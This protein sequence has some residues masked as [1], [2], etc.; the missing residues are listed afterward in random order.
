MGEAIP[1][2]RRLSEDLTAFRADFMRMLD[3][4]AIRNIDPNRWGGG[5]FVGFPEWGW[6][7]SDPS[8]ERT[9]ME[10][11]AR[12]KELAHRWRL[13]FPTPTPRVAETLDHA[14]D[15]IHI[16]IQ[17]EAGDQSV[18]G[19]IEAAKATG[20]ECFGQLQELLTMLPAD[21]VPVRLVVDTNALI[22]DPDLTIY[23][24]TMG[25]HYTV[26]LLPVVLGELDDLHRAGRTVELRSAAAAAGRRI[27]GYR[28]NGDIR[29]GVRVQAKIYMQFEH[30]EPDMTTTLHW[31]DRQVPDDRLVAAALDLQVR[32]PGSAA[33]DQPGRPNT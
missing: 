19:G 2:R 23:K 12:W 26:H 24:P 17:R 7:P 20:D 18:P 16:W 21:P 15:Q 1:F 8:H 31:L 14:L 25:E 5:G 22:D 30:A 27:K 11:L 28:G 4:S 9:R 29:S 6:A 13:L 3:G 32:H 10:L 33:G